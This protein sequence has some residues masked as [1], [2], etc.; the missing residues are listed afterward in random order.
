M[1]L[2]K[3]LRMF[4]GF[5]QLS[6]DPNKLERVFAIAESRLTYAVIRAAST[7]FANVRVSEN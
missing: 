1:N 6:Q 4:H 2:V 5:W 7:R 3:T